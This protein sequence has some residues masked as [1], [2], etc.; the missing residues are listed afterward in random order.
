MRSSK[1]YM[2]TNLDNV[3]SPGIH[4][5]FKAS[6]ALLV[7]VHLGECVDL[8]LRKFFYPNII[9]KRFKGKRNV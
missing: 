8:L 9:K 1:K 3:F 2:N 5:G 4:A 7:L 6:Q